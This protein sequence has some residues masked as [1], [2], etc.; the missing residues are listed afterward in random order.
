[1]TSTKELKSQIAVE[2]IHV[3]KAIKP[4]KNY[5]EPVKMQ[6]KF[7]YGLIKNTENKCVERSNNGQGF[8]Y[9]ITSGFFHSLETPYITWSCCY[10]LVHCIIPKGSTY[11][12]GIRHQYASDM[13][14][15]GRPIKP[16]TWWR[17]VKLFFLR[18]QRKM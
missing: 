17:K 6:G 15:V 11:F 14:I 3:Y 5:W 10:T 4:H 13:I 1:M 8:L 9:N 12:K 7:N 2:D 16:I 18:F